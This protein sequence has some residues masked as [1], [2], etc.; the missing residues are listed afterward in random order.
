[1]LGYFFLQLTL[2]LEE[3]AIQLWNWAV[4][5]NVGT[6][7]S[8]HQKAKG[9]P[10][11][12]SISLK[13]GFTDHHDAW[14]YSHHLKCWHNAGTSHSCHVAFKCSHHPHSASRCMQSA[15]LQWAWAADRG[16][17][18]QANPGRKYCSHPQW[19]LKHFRMRRS[20]CHCLIFT[21][22]QQNRENLVGLQKSPDGRLLL[23][24]C[25]QGEKKKKKEYS[26]QEIREKYG[27]LTNDST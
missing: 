1:M 13:D 16:R 7:I 5:K 4:T 24:T 17:P 21:D 26:N 14:K 2:Q 3:C 23:K 12:C 18:P 20:V 6:I 19:E 8:K 25:C 27:V 9:K 15:V 10:L 11:I 22:G